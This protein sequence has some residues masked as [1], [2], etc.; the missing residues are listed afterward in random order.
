MEAKQH[1]YSE[2]VNTRMQ[3][4]GMT[5]VTQC[6]STLCVVCT[7]KLKLTAAV[8]G[9]FLFWAVDHPRCAHYVSKS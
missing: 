3:S 7:K 2:E 5:E 1:L 4:Y 9:C 6:S 8:Y